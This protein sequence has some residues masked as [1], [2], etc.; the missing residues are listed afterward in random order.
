V[1][2]ETFAG[3][4]SP[5]SAHFGKRYGIVAQPMRA[6]LTAELT[7]PAENGP[8]YRSGN[9]SA[10]LCGDFD[11]RRGA[12]GRCRCVAAECGVVLQVECLQEVGT[13][14]RCAFRL[15]VTAG[16]VLS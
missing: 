3:R 2:P 14:L 6:G 12:V 16:S 10:C 9:A 11:G 1:W 15:I 7:G 4:G 5:A 8:C 13:D